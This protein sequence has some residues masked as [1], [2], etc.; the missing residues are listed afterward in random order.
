MKRFILSSVAVLVLAFSAEAGNFR[1]ASAEE[2]AAALE[3]F[4]RVSM[5]ARRFV[6]DFVQTRHTSLL[7]EDLV[8]K[9]RLTMDAPDSLVWAYISPEKKTYT[10]DL[11]SDAR[12]KAMGRRQDFSREVLMG[13][14][15]TCRIVLKPL[16]R[17]LKKLFSLVEVDM[18]SG[19]FSKVKMTEASGDFTL[20]EFGNAVGR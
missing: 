16:K 9:G 15:G 18:V 10:V 4:D 20:I 17:D 2:T 6:C 13:T 14:D 12:F 11:N 7:D 1:A 8:S 19:A 3:T 5:E